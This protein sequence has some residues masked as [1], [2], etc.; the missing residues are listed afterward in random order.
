VSISET[1]IANMALAR[2]GAKRLTNIDTD[3]SQEATQALL[4]YA[5]TRDALLRSHWWRFAIARATLSE[6]VDAPDFEYDHQ[7]TLPADYLRGIGLY[8]T[9]ATFEIEGQHLLTDDDTVELKYVQRLTDPTKFDP[10]FVEVLV[11][12]LAIKFV[13]PLAQD[14][15]LRRELQDELKGVKTQARLVNMDETNTMGREDSYTW[16]DARLGGTTMGQATP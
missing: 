16:N 7:Y 15:V 8:D 10:L 1:S 4:H 14:K 13:M 11:L 12:E 2:I 9:T 6:D 5:Q 3:A